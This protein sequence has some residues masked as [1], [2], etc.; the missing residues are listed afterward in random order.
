MPD[1]STGRRLH[2][3]AWG[4]D[5]RSAKRGHDQ[6]QCSRLGQAMT[7]LELHSA[8]LGAKAESSGGQAVHRG[9]PPL[10]C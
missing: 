3:V 2:S 4:G 1:I 5:S 10:A 8:G 6:A 9:L 7:C